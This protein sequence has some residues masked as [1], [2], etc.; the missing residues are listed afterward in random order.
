MRKMGLKGKLISAFL[1]AGLVPMMGVGVYTY[2]RSKNNLEKQAVERLQAIRDVK[3]IGIQNYFKVIEE[4]VLTYSDNVSI[5]EA[6][7]AFS[8]AFKN[9]KKEN[10]Y[11]KADIFGFKQKLKKFY[12]NEFGKK[13]REANG[14]DINTS[15][16]ISRLSDTEVIHQ[17]HYIFSN[18][19]E[20]GTKDRLDYST[21]DKSEYSKVHAKYHPSIRHFLSSFK[22]YDIFLVDHKTGNIVYSVYKE[23][24]FGTSLMNGAFS[25]SGIAKVFKEA[26][27]LEA[28]DRFAFSDYDLYT[29]SY[30]AP[31]AFIASPIFNKGKKV[32]ILIFQ[33]P[34]DQVNTVMGERSGLGESGETFIVGQDFKMR[35]DSYLKKDTHSVAA[36]YR[37][38]ENG[39]ID[40]LATRSSTSG[41]EGWATIIDYTNK[42]SIIA[43]TPL[44]VF[45]LNWGIN[46]K[47]YTSEA[48][49]EVKA[50]ENALLFTFAFTCLAVFALAFYISGTISN[51]I[52]NV[53]IKLLKGARD[54]ERSSQTVSQTS[55]QL[56]DAGARSASSLQETVASIDEISS[57][58]QKNADAAGR[59]TQVSASSAEAATKG[60]QTVEHMIRSIN[61]IAESNN[62]IN[63][64]AQVIAEIGEK[65]KVIND[66]VFQTKLLSIN[67]SVEAAR[68]GEHGKGF[69]VVAEEVGNL[70][71]VSGKA[72][73]EITNM[74]DSSIKHV[75][76]IVEKTKSKVQ[77]GT[78]TAEECGEALDEILKNVSTVNDMVKEIASASAEQSTGVRE[79]TKAMQQLDQ[80][81]HEN[82]TVAQESS[83]MA[84]T[85]NEQAT[86]LSSA[87]K[88][89][90]D[91]VGVGMEEEP[92]HHDDHHW[93]EQSFEAE[94]SNV[95]E[96]TPAAR[97][98]VE[99]V[100]EVQPV[101]EVKVSG[102]DTAVPQADDP[103]FEDL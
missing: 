97:V 43:Y 89:L 81:S 61:D 33:M 92:E 40:T 2:K 86:F 24:D 95:V 7:V 29:P 80:S 47:I 8:D 22:Y 56:S 19:N 85:L 35:S 68:A 100:Q 45:G 53:A 18:K 6:M 41:K 30:D 83:K 91:I 93:K 10:N 4:Q 65:T 1:F 49:A 98:E 28:A 3:K 17:Y 25:N 58:V 88:E 52:T 5:Q 44:K 62:E 46:A 31:A 102:L 73:L 99:P 36:S 90:N 26:N 72:A 37:D 55:T 54:V 78:K 101:E 76:D 15:R 64:I 66:I 75:T 27:Q 48:F 57:M 23:L 13:Y 77:S 14:S 67:A 9:V 82:T 79:V 32:G 20:L 96:F 39:K 87:V 71:A 70:A 60:K 11:T 42:E 16:F 51:S 21:L 63:Q 12:S 34:I 50:L 69:A 84:T 38:P 59:S 103:R 94:H 74:L